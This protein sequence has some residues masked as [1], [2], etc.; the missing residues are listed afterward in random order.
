MLKTTIEELISSG[1]TEQAIADAVGSTQPTINRI[2]TGETEDPK[3]S[4]GRS[5]ERLHQDR[6]QRGLIPGKAVA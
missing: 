3:H 2:R 4:L 1:L 6:L 5:L